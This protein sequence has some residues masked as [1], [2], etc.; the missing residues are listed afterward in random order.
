MRKLIGI[1]NRAP[2]SFTKVVTDQVFF[3]IVAPF[4]D[5]FMKIVKMDYSKRMADWLA[6]VWDKDLLDLGGGTGINAVALTEAG[7]RVTVVDSS[8]SM[9]AQAKTKGIKAE[10]IQA[11]AGAL[12]LPDVSYDIVLVSDAWHHFRKQGGVIGEI[13]RVLRPGGRLYIIDFDREKFRTKYLIVLE[14]LLGEPST[15][16]TPKE[17]VAAF[18]SRGIHGDFDYITPNQFLFRGNSST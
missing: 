14:K 11:D 13:D 3:K 8:R 6:P 1:I 4:Y 9:L 5:R 10:L 15:F 7:A 2:N 12:P 18:K 16:W 17:L